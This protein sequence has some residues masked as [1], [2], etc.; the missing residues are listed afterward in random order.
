MNY[1]YL[2]VLNTIY[3]SLSFSAQAEIFFA[4]SLRVFVTGITMTLFSERIPVY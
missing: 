4:N 3:P 1:T 2:S